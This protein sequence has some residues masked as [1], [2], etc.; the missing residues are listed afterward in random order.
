VFSVPAV[1]VT[2]AVAPV[3][4]GVATLD[5]FASVHPPPTP[6]KVTL[7]MTFP[8]KSTVAPVDVAVNAIAEVVAF[9][10]VSVIPETITKLDPAHVNVTAAAIVNTPA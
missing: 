5:P 8:A 9:P 6:L 7:P 10:S 2:V 3:W 1:C 4:N